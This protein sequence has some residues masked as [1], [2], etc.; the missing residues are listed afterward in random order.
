M[1]YK[2]CG[3]QLSH[4]FLFA[5][6]VGMS[7]VENRKR[8]SSLLF[9]VPLTKLIN[10]SFCPALCVEFQLCIYKPPRLLHRGGRLFFAYLVFEP[11]ISIVAGL[12]VSR[13]S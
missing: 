13:S 11:I 2:R 1:E 9:F 3:K 8:F 12:Q 4:L 10:Y 5:N 7:E 6:V